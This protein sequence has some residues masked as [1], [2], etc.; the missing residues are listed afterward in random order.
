MYIIRPAKPDDFKGFVNLINKAGAGITTLPNSQAAAKKRLEE[1]LLSFETKV[2]KPSDQN[3]LFLLEDL[4]T[5]E[6]G[7]CC[8]ILGDVS[9]FDTYT[10]KIET[11]SLLQKFSQSAQ[12]AKVL[13]FASG[14]SHASEICSLFL[15]QEWRK[16][17]LGKLLSL[18]RFLFMANHPERFE[19]NV[20]A[21]MRG[22]IDE[23][24]ENPFWNAISR[25]FLDIPYAEFAQLVQSNPQV[26]LDVIPKYP[27]YISMLP[28][29]A[30]EIIGKA[31]V[32]TIPALN[33]LIEQ[34]FSFTDRIDPGDAGP[35]ITAETKNIKAIKDSQVFLIKSITDSPIESLRH[36]IS[37][38]K[39]D[40]RAC[41]ATISVDNASATIEKNVAD[42]LGL[43]I[44]DTIRVIE[45]EIKR[46]K[47]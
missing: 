35:I 14:Y 8:G 25:H 47:N 41:F 46:T 16:K 3:Y 28:K 15:A 2:I 43:T 13:H 24:G 18:S 30:Q 12:T 10:Y 40:F 34:G 26:V 20:I 29:D 33:M 27:I 23:N 6:I 11:V 45:S 9:C 39:V 7:A 4:E 36:I 22:A 32:N 31:H 38:V 21:A 17:N 5:K 42:A 44:G 19:R 1:S 37:N